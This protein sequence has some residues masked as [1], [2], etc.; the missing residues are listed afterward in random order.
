MSNHKLSPAAPGSPRRA[1][2]RLLSLCLVLLSVSVLSST[3]RADS[4]VLTTGSVSVTV[5]P[6]QT[7]IMVGGS[8]P[9]SLSYFNSEYAGAL[10]TS[11]SFQ[12]I[13]EGF[14]TVSF[15][16]LSAQ[17]FTGL[18]SYNNTLLTGQVTAFSTL[19]DV[20][21]NQP[22]F[23]VTFS[24][25]GVLVSNPTSQTFNVVATPEPATLLLLSS[26]L[27]AIAAGA[28]KRRK[29]A[30]QRRRGYDTHQLI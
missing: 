8:G 9:F 2:L 11:F 22:L 30:A 10:T 17:F 18:V 25:N 16:G 20:L 4:V 21:L 7:S 3:A 12:S 27:A 24:G 6:G 15:N 23:T 1:A 28:H 26:G 5:P 29:V 19:N 13:T 14:G